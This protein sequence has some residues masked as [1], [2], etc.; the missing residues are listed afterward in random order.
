MSWEEAH[1]LARE[2]AYKIRS[3]RYLPDAIIG[4]VR[5]GLVPSMMFSDLLDVKDMLFIRIEHWGVTGE[6][7]NKAKLKYPLQADIKGK[8]ILLIDDLTDTG[9]TLKLALEEVVRHGPR[10]VRTATLIHK[11]QSS[12]RPDYFAQATGK[13]EW[14]IFPWNIN[15]DIKNLARKASEGKNLTPKELGA[16]LKERFNLD[17]DAGTLERIASSSSSTSGSG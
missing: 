7:D 4:V 14:I 12:C 10:E 17:L 9:D 13:W 1:E 8:K 2:T 5:G 3:D 16:R 11:D 15:E 6:K